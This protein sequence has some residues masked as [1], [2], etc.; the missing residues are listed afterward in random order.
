MSTTG[1]QTKPIKKQRAAAHTWG[2]GGGGGVEKRSKNKSGLRLRGERIIR[3]FWTHASSVSLPPFWNP[4]FCKFVLFGLMTRTRWWSAME[5]ER[6]KLVL[7]REI[8]MR[9]KERDFY[10]IH[11]QHFQ[12]HSHLI[13]AQNFPKLTYFCINKHYMFILQ[14]NYI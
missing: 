13:N 14:N 1:D 6:I 7:E 2:R 4:S 9:E 3:K 8:L 10:A 5:E 11:Q 12:S